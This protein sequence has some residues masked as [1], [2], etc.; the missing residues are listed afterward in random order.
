M[1][2]YIAYTKDEI[3]LPIAVA[4]STTE[5]ARL[6]GRS[7]SGIESVISKWRMGKVKNPSSACVEVEDE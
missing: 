3:R 1:K 4:N 2:I 5:L 6:T 7:K